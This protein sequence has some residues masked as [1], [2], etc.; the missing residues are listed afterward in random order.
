MK[1][2]IAASLLVASALAT[3]APS[4][5]ESVRE[6]TDALLQ[7]LVE[8]QPLYESSP[9]AFFVEVDKSLAPHIDFDGFARGVMAKYYRRADDE[10]KEAFSEKFRSALIQTYAKALV[11]F[12]NEKVEIVEDGSGVDPKRPDRA[13]VNLEVHGSDGTIYPV[14]YSLALV[15]DQWKLRNVVVEGIN[16]GLQFRSQFGE[17]MQKYRNDIDEVI[18]NWNVDD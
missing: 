8:I 15:D 7:R 10:Q 1:W 12:D 13:V 6:S 9:E 5:V 16:L 4:P 14:Q 2:L 3:A 18:A 11:G 17:Y